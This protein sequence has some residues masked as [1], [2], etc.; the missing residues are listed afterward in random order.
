MLYA[1]STETRWMRINRPVTKC[2]QRHIWHH[3]ALS[4]AQWYGEMQ[5]SSITLVLMTGWEEESSDSTVWWESNP[6]QTKVLQQDTSP[7]RGVNIKEKINFLNSD[8]SHL[9]EK[10][11]LATR[12][13]CWAIA[14]IPSLHAPG[15]LEI[16]ELYHKP[17]CA[18]QHSQLLSMDFIFSLKKGHTSIT[19]HG[20]LHWEIT[21]HYQWGYNRSLY[22]IRK[23]QQFDLADG[24]V[25]CSQYPDCY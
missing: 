9:H 13:S 11:T 16:V 10:D 20:A 14:D 6:E 23:I 7:L 25:I 22:C 3:H 1:L 5:P 8:T 21:E 17:W 15:K 18:A 12:P 2:S 24:C 19:V 4:H